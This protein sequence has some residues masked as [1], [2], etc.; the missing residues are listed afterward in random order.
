MTA[1]FLPLGGR[2]VQYYFC[3]PLHLLEGFYY[4]S[5]NHFDE[6]YM[7]VLTAYLVVLYP[8]SLQRVVMR[9]GKS[10]WLTGIALIGM[11]W[12]YGGLH[13]NGF[14]NVAFQFFFMAAGTS[15]L[16]INGLFSKDWIT[17][18]LSHPLWYP[19]ARI[20]Y[21]LYLIHPLMIY[22][23]LSLYINYH[24]TIGMTRPVFVLFLAT[25]W[26]LSSLLAAFLF[27]WMERPLIHLGHRLE[28]I[29]HHLR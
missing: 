13:S 7:G 2:I 20:S 16:I 12:G 28:S 14:F 8:V 18:F 5:H 23:F 6:L 1:V 24:G 3:R 22:L 19:T 27:Y 11:V 9:L 17:A 29:A 10:L 21:G 15:I 25:V 4:Y 26:G